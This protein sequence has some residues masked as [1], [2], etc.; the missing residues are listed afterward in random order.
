MRD[1]KNKKIS[2]KGREALRTLLQGT[3][4]CN[5]EMFGQGG[6]QG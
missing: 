5:A 6:F 4:P 2:W 3:S 1:G